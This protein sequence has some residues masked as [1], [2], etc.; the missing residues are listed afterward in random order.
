MS[1][2]KPVELT[3]FER[4]V[5]I[6]LLQTALSGWEG[7]AARQSAAQRAVEKLKAV[8]AVHP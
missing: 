2:T 4:D 7:D 1:R 8:D 6:S 5:T 3:D